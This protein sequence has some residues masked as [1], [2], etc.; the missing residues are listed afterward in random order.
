MQQKRLSVPLLVCVILFDCKQTLSTNFEKFYNLH[1]RNLTRKLCSQKM[2]SA[3][4]IAAQFNQNV[5][6]P[7]N[8]CTARNLVE[9]GNNVSQ[10][11]PNLNF[12]IPF[13]TGPI[14]TI[15]KDSKLLFE[16][17]INVKVEQPSPAPGPAQVVQNSIQNSSDNFNKFMKRAKK[18]D[19]MLL[20]GILRP[21]ILHHVTIW[22]FLVD[23]TLG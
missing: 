17:E 9:N 7:Q 22:D 8:L 15:P 6:I 2:A 10:N 14:L 3:A 21:K 18:L 1:D 11:P 19:P 16:P 23:K 12:G 13:Q 4:E 5:D 20:W